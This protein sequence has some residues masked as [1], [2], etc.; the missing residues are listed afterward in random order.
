MLAS[1]FGIVADVNSGRAGIRGERRNL[2]ENWDRGVHGY[3]MLEASTTRRTLF[4]AQYTKIN[5]NGQ[6][7]S[8]YYVAATSSTPASWSGQ[9]ILAMLSSQYASNNAQA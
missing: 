6:K 8:I 4:T 7:A 3:R 5:S 1:L 9:L 2:T